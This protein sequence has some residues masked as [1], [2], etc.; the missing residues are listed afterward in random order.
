MSRGDYAHTDFRQMENPHRAR[1]ADRHQALQ[2]TASLNRAHLAEGAHLEPATDGSRRTCA[3]QGLP[4]SA[5]ARR[6][7]SDRHRPQPQNRHRRSMELGRRLQ[8]QARR[9]TRR[10]MRLSAIENPT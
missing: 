2:R 3:S 9:L 8:G 6:I 7:L 4:R 10:P 1:P 5:A